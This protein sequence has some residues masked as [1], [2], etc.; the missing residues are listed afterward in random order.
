[1]NSS[2]NGEIDEP[3]NELGRSGGE[4]MCV[5]E[6]EN[7]RLA[8]KNEERSAFEE[9]KETELATRIVS[10]CGCDVLGSLV[11]L[12]KAENRLMSERKT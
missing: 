10:A 9:S 8:E 2:V 11:I 1:V 12:N 7:T 6:T 3:E 5:A 4:A